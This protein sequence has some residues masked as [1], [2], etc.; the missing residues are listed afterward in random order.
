MIIRA[1]DKGFG[2]FMVAGCEHTAQADENHIINKIRARLQRSSPEVFLLEPNNCLSDFGFRFA[3]CL[4][5]HDSLSQFGVVQVTIRLLNFSR[6]LRVCCMAHNERYTATTKT[7][8]RKNIR[9]VFI[10]CSLK[11]IKTTA[12]KAMVLRLLSD[13]REISFRIYGCPSRKIR[14]ATPHRSN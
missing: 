4:W 13:S 8:N 3:A 6:S 12:Y 5:F 10:I 11:K 7:L 14:A 1:W 2:Q 9:F